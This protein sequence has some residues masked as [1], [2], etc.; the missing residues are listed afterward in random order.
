MSTCSFDAE[1]PHLLSHAP[2][3]ADAVADLQ[4]FSTPTARLEK[5][6]VVK[7]TQGEDGMQSPSQQSLC[8]YIQLELL[9]ALPSAHTTASRTITQAITY[10]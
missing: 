1:V 5:R 9:L 3:Y 4:S 8:I 2:R 7:M 6:R 10:Y